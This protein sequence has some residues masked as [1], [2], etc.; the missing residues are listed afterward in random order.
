MIISFMRN[1]FQ[2]KKQKHLYSRNGEIYTKKPEIE[3]AQKQKTKESSGKKEQYLKTT[4]GSRCY[5]KPAK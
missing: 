2:S 5:T 4:A 3:K 1:H